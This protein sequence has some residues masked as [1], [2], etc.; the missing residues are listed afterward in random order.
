M[1]KCAKRHWNC[2]SLYGTYQMLRV[3]SYAWHGPQRAWQ[4]PAH[5]EIFL[6]MM[7]FEC[8]P[9]PKPGGFA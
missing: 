3:M 5:C 9:K 2:R 1:Y 8:P 7:S 6:L 4:K